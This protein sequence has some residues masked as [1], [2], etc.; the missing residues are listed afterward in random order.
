MQ[1]VLLSLLGA[2]L[3]AGPVVARQIKPQG[4]LELIGLT[5]VPDHLPTLL[6]ALVL[7]GAF[8]VEWAPALTGAWIIYY[9]NRRQV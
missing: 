8:L 4:I 3:L 2:A 9:A 6:Q 5:A 1:R 7:A